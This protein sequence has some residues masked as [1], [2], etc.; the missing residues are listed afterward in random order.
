MAFSDSQTLSATIATVSES[1]IGT[2]NV[3]SGR[4]YRLTSLFVAH[5]QGGTSRIAIDT[6]PA[7]QGKYLQNSQDYLS[8][9][10][11][12]FTPMNIAVNGP[13]EITIYAS[14][15]AATSGIAKAA[16]GYIDSGAQ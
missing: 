5:P 6:Y 12:N 15:A 7:L 10:N 11:N 2:I 8:T 9:I 13:A 3:P 14:N 1:S 4:S 16:L